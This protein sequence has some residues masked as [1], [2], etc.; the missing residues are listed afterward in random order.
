MDPHTEQQIMSSETVCASL[1]VLFVTVKGEEAVS[2]QLGSES[3]KHT[4]HTNICCVESQLLFIHI[5][6]HLKTF[7]T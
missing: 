7:P 2:A 5:F 3:A 4:Y 1:A 6:V